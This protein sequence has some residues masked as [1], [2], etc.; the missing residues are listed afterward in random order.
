MVLPK[1]WNEFLPI[2]P[3][4][5][6]SASS[7]VTV[8]ALCFC[9][10]RPFSSTVPDEMLNARLRKGLAQAGSEACNATC[11]SALASARS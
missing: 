5:S 11:A 8:C 7:P 3:V 1:F 2:C 10:T 6:A 9:V 4:K